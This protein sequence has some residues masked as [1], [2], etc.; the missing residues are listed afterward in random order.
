MTELEINKKINNLNF[1]GTNK[2]LKKILLYLFK[3]TN[4][5]TNT[6][7]VDLDI[8]TYIPFTNIVPFKDF[9][10]VMQQKQINEPITITPNTVGAIPGANA[11]LRLV[12]DGIQANTPVF[13]NAQQITGSSGWDN[14][15]GIVNI[16]QMQ[17]DGSS[18]YF[19]IVQT[20]LGDVLDLQKPVLVSSEID[21]SGTTAKLTFNEDLLVTSVPKLTDFSGA[22]ITNLVILNKVVTLKISPALAT[23]T[24]KII[25]SGIAIKDLAG[26]TTLAFT[27]DVTVT[28]KQVITPVNLASRD[29]GINEISIGTYVATSGGG[30]KPA[31]ANGFVFVDDKTFEM[32][33]SSGT[34]GQGIIGLDATAKSA[35]ILGD[36]PN[37]DL[38]MAWYGGNYQAMQEGKG[39]IP[40]GAY[41]GGDLVRLKRVKGLITAE[42]KRGAGVWT[43]L[44]NFP[45]PINV[46][47][48]P[49]IYLNDA[50][51]QTSVV[52]Y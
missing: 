33:A 41:V 1:F 4:S 48:V 32:T 51:S 16:V 11:I 24:T 2:E 26:N 19:S 8:A 29:T 47:L 22:T 40:C 42:Y 21:E 27:T 44:F 23:G 31:I 50:T 12:A 39:Q 35:A 15:A 52:I 36:W 46:P 37:L 28:A 25:Y 14:R 45:N 9:P 20:A 13:L 17:F 30:W 34:F 6:E 7:T 49:V 5:S 38:G 10:C 3:N 18:F 43:N